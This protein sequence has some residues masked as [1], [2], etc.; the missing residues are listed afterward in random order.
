MM[1]IGFQGKLTI[2]SLS[3]VILTICCMTGVNFVNSRSNYLD[4]GLASLEDVSHTLSET[5]TMQDRLARKKIVSDL[6]IFKSIMGISGLPMFEMLYDVDMTLTNQETGATEAATIPAFK[7]GTKYLHESTELVDSMLEKADVLTSVLQLNGDKLIRVSSTLPGPDGNSAQGIYIPS[8]SGAYKAIEGGKRF[9]GIVSLAG[10][11][12]VVACEAVRDYDDKVMGA[13]EVA[14]PVISNDFSEFIKSVTVGGKGYSYVFRSNG[15]F[16]VEPVEPEVAEAIKARVLADPSM[17]TEGGLISLPVN[18]EEVWA[19][20]VRFDPW[21]A[22]LVTE[23][24]S[25]ELLAGVN[26]QIIVSAAESALPPLVLALLIIWFMSR[27]LMAPMNRL[28]SIAHEV[29]KGNFDCDFEYSANDAIGRTMASVKGMVAEMKNQLGFSRGVLEGVTIPCSVVDLDN[30]ITHINQAAVKVLGKRKT[31]DK[32]FGMLFNEVLYHDAKR[33]TLTQVAMKKRQQVEWEIDL[34][35]DIDAVTVI[36]HVVAT[37]IYDLDG[38]LI[39]AIT[40]WVDLTEERRQKKAVEA[41]NALIEDAAREATAIAQSVSDSAQELSE[42][43][44]IAS[45]GAGQQSDRSME[46]SSAMEEMNS[47]VMEIARN[48]SATAV[49]SQ[50]TS[51]LARDGAEIVGK[52]VAMMRTVHSQSEGLR[53]KMSELGQHANGIG[54]IMGVITDIADQTNLLALN[55]AIEAARAGEAGRGFAVVADEVRKLAEKTMD[56]TKQVGQYIR[57]IQQSAESN[58]KSTDEATTALEECRAMVE[59]SGESLEVIVAKADEAAAQVQSIAAAA[60]QQSTTSDEINQATEMVNR[61]AGDTAR[62]M[63]ESAAAINAL[64]TLARDLRAAIGKM[65]A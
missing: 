42:T 43:I 49:M 63:Q 45:E 50:E 48:A 47:S 62:S 53:S 41:K 40:I 23:V 54:A 46:V 64:N 12:Y 36:L 1:S 6:S 10:G 65:Q 44:R 14:R 33:K 39:G 60:E 37:P 21:D 4:S 30:N 26:K 20:V 17:R 2:A 58:I 22:Y 28:A 7:L 18:G 24:K 34:T 27:Q 51:G 25:S 15:E 55:A 32:Y 19:H 56:A 11:W 5:V 52:S 35:R 13:L 29:G 3:I 59:Q 61:I 57:S 16:P 31:P 8:D 38:Q 9:E